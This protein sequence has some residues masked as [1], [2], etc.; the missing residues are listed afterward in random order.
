MLGEAGSLGPRVKA[1]LVLGAESFALVAMKEKIMA[2][3][4]EYIIVKH[5]APNDDVP[6]E[7]AE[8][9]SDGEGDALVSNPPNKTKKHK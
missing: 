8:D 4:K 3:L 7:S 9:D 2:M 1:T 6:D 5:N